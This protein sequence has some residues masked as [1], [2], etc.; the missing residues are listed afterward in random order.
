M[1]ILLRANPSHKSKVK[2]E[3][4]SDLQM[5]AHEAADVK[6]AA[7]LVPKTDFTCC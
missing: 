3:S 4:L 7:A 1:M 6:G 5:P 2:F